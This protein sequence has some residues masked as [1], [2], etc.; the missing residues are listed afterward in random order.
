M[1]SEGKEV[2]KRSITYFTYNE[3]KKISFNLA[4]SLA[5]YNLTYTEP[6]HKMKLISIYSP[7][8]YE[9]IVTDI[10]CIMLGITSVPLYDTLG[11]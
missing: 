10:A 11:I 1:G 4:K 6:Y 5:K 2:E 8:R 3:L 9:W 7:N